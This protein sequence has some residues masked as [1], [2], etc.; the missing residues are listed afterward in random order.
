MEIGLKRWFDHRSFITERFLKITQR[1]SLSFSEDDPQLW[2]RRELPVAGGREQRPSS[3]H[4]RVS[5]C[6]AMELWH[7]AAVSKWKCS[8]MVA[9]ILLQVLREHK[10]I[11]MQNWVSICSA[12]MGWTVYFLRQ[13]SVGRRRREGIPV[14]S[15]GERP[16]QPYCSPSPQGPEASANKARPVQKPRDCD[17]HGA[18]L[19]SHTAFSPR[20]S[21]QLFNTSPQATKQLFLNV[22]SGWANAGKRSLWVISKK[23]TPRLKRLNSVISSSAQTNFILICPPEAM[24][25]WGCMLL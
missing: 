13:G 18:A 17:V 20:D 23:Q 5:C 12:S 10:T 9:H 6:G 7:C 19:L 8:L 2:L 1:N 11:L 3:L 21:A 14:R 15:Q 16:A 4:W 22:L 24:L 25:Y